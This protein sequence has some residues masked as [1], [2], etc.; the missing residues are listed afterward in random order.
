MATDLVR[1]FLLKFTLLSC[2]MVMSWPVDA[3][4]SE[5]E[6]IAQIY[7][8]AEQR[9]AT[10][11]AIQTGLTSNNVAIQKQAIL[12]LGRIGDI[13]TSKTISSACMRRVFFCRQKYPAPEVRRSFYLLTSQA[14]FFVICR[15]QFAL[16]GT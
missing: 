14:N 2:L 12:A 7:E 13:R 10:A 6:H 3:R 9:N 5:A 15:L 4:L 11:K 1:H 16:D 8:A